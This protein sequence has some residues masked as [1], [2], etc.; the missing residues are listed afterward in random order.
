MNV[1]W[2]DEDNWEEEEYVGRL[3]SDL[4]IFHKYCDPTNMT[5][6]D[7]LVWEKWNKEFN[8]QNYLPEEL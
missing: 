6:E 5:Y 3:E 2:P 8:P 7:H 4:E 1:F